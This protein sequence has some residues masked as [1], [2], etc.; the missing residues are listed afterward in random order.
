MLNLLLQFERSVN[1][2]SGDKDD[3]GK[4][5]APPSPPPTP[6]PQHDPRWIRPLKKGDDNPSSKPR[7]KKPSR[8]PER[9][10]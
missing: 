6:P 4:R 8:T 2:M 10:A 9:K 1:I 5:K 7:E 3:K